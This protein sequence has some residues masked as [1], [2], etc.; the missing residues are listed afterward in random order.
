LVHSQASSNVNVQGDW[1]KQDT[2]RLP[3]LVRALV[4]DNAQS[5]DIYLLQAPRLIDQW[6]A[7]VDLM[8]D[9]SLPTEPD[10]KVISSLDS[11]IN[12]HSSPKC[13][14]TMVTRGDSLIVQELLC[15]KSL[16]HCL[17][18]PQSVR[19]CQPKAFGNEY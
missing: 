9:V 8:L 3:S 12:A 5:V 14:G 6:K 11:S 2:S 15:Y 17:Q 16:E 13:Y 19:I 7:D 1:G 4:F 10:S 18:I